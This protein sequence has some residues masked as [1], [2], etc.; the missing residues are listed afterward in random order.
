MKQTKKILY[1]VYDNGELHVS[2]SKGNLKLGNIPG[3]NLL[4]GDE[5]LQAKNGQLTNIAGTCGK[6]CKDCIK[7]CYAVRYVKLRQNSCVKPYAMNT[8]IMRN[9]PE[10]L[11][12][13]IKD[14]CTKNIVKYFRF[15]SAGEIES[16]EQLRLYGLICTDNPDV[17][18]YTYTKA[19]DILEAWFKELSASNTEPPENFVINLSEWHE[20]LDYLNKVHP[21]FSRF[22]NVFAYDDCTDKRYAE[23]PHCPAIN[24]RGHETGVTCAQCRR[25]LQLKHHTAIYSH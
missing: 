11:R 19:F 1:P 20:N 3:L 9:N 24:I 5:P 13:A 14:Y 18:F 16:L 6:Y 17:V 21:Y 4:P 23:M 12:A 25:C 8:L 10:K 2:I 22:C 15:H 7:N